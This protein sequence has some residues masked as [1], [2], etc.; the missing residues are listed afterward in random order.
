M[1]DAYKWFKICGVKI[2]S[3]IPKGS[4]YILPNGEY[5]HLPESGYRTH[6]ALDQA[7]RDNGYP[8]E[9][10]ELIYLLPI[11]YM[12]CIRINDGSNFLA[13]V[14][15]DLPR[16]RITSA[17]LDSIETYINNLNKDEILVGSVVLGSAQT[18][19]LNYTSASDIRSK[20]RGFYSSGVLH[21]K[22]QEV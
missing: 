9:E 5:A 22:E 14:V 12:H 8:V 13:E 16:E 15:V 2:D 4:A 17:Q 18:Y 1:N 19:N 7:L 10:D 11:E 6:G 3:S 20:I 21:E